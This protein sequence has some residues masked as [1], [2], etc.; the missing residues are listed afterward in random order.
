MQAGHDFVFGAA[1]LDRAAA[2][3]SQPEAV[4]AALADPAARVVPLWRGRPLLHGDALGWLAAAHPLLAAMAEPPIL[5]GMDG[6]APRF[7]ADIGDWEPEPP[8]TPAAPASLAET[9]RQGHPL[10]GAEWG[11]AELRAVMTVLPAA[12]AELA[13]TARA[14]TLWHR[15]HRHC[16]ACGAR[17]EPD[18]A[19]WQRRC[20]SCGT[21]HF[22]R[23]DPVVI[24]LVTRGNRALI[25]RS[26]GWPEGMYSC[27]A[28]F[29]EPGETLETAVRREVMEETGIGIGPVRYL[30]SQPW[31]FPASLM[32]GCH[33]IATSEAITLDPVEL[34]DAQ[35]ISREDLV[36]VFAGAHPRI[37]APRRGAIAGHLLAGWLADRWR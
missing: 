14:L 8:A 32:I 12:D 10:L 9:A 3:R 27:L 1:G 31:P 20:P 15:S 37:R 2:L 19:G 6:G 23:T 29:V 35:W 5:L 24:M 11:F 25:G 28:G 17:S 18:Q 34:E 13:A 26:G 21:R 36:E 30:A 7:A 22:P 33:G 4:A 16:S